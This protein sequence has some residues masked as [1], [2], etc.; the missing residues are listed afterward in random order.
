M[1]H[2]SGM[3]TVNIPIYTINEKGYKLPVS[4]DY[5]S[6]GIKVE[7]VASRVGIGWAL[8]YGGNIS[9][10][11][12]GSADESTY[13]Y[14]NLD[15][16][17]DFFTNS[18]TRSSV[19]SAST[20]HNYDFVPD[21]FY[22]SANG[23][24]GKFIFDQND[25]QPVLQEFE[26]T[27]ISYTIE[28]SKIASF[29]VTDEYGNK[30]Y[31]G[32]S[33]DGSRN[34]RDYDVTKLITQVQGESVVLSNPS[35]TEYY[36]TWHL[37][38]IETPDDGKIEFYYV[39]EIPV[40]YRRSYDKINDDKKP[41]SFFSK[42]IGHQYQ[43]SEIRF[44]TGKLVFQKS[45]TERSDLDNAYAL[46]RVEL[47]D[48]N[49]SLV[50]K[51]QFGYQY[52]TA[53]SNGNQLSY[54][55]T[56]ESQAAKRL[57]LKSIQEK[58]S[59]NNALPAYSFDYNSTVLPNRFSNSQDVWGYYNG[60][61]N[62][63]YLT[64]FNYASYNV[65]R[66]VQG[67]YSGAGLLTKITFPTGGSTEYTY[68]QNVA[69]PSA[70]MRNII[71]QNI[72]PLETVSDGLGFLDLSYYDGRR[73]YIKP[74]TIGNISGVVNVSNFWVQNASI[75]DFN[76]SIEGIGGSPVYSLIPGQTTFIDIGSG[77]Y[78][79]K[80]SP[81]SSGFDP[82][83][84]DHGFNINL[85]WQQ[86]EVNQN[87][88]IYAGGKRINTVVNKLAD[89]SVASRK[90][91]R[92][93]DSQGETTGLIFGMPNCYTLNKELSIG[94]FQVFEAYGAVPGSPLNM[95]Q[96][97]SVG[98]SKVTEYFGT[99][100]SN[101]GRTD[102]EFTDLE[103]TGD[104]YKFPYTM[105]TD[106]E[107]LRGKPL[108]IANYR[109]KT[110]GSFELVK[111]VENEYLYGDYVDEF[112]SSSYNVF[113]PF[114]GMNN[115]I[116]IS[117]SI[118][119][120]L[121]RLYLKNKRL[122]RFPL[123]I[124]AFEMNDYG[125][126]DPNGDVYYKIYHITGGSL[127]LNKTQTTDY[128]N[129][130]ASLITTTDYFYNYDDHYQLSRTETTNSNGDVIK[131]YLRY[132][133]DYNSGVENFNT[134]ISNNI[135]GKVVD[136]RTYNGSLL[137]SGIQNKFNNDGLVTD[138]YK[139]ETDVTDLAFN[140]GNAYT[141]SHEANYHYTNSNLDQVFPE[142]DIKTVYLWDSKG[143]YV[144]A[145]VE[146][147]TYSQLSS[148][149]NKVCTYSSKTLYNNIKSLV[150]GA[151]ITT[152]SYD[153]LIGISE[154]TDTNGVTS[155]FEYDSFGRLKFVKNDDSH[156]QNMVRYNYGSN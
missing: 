115:P 151:I 88:L 136:N 73:A 97:N 70:V 118:T 76:F 5:H 12:R 135:V 1:S 41:E 144:M 104:Y 82:Y 154:Q 39:E 19:Y 109:K 95:G 37:M 68:D 147:A 149:Q 93:V 35:I 77:V 105:P 150:S 139:F 133:Q 89:G 26:N 2:Y 11:V 54:L 10:Q 152:Y 36:N 155:Y 131:N 101:Q 90:E 110:D 103:N 13:G 23:S 99:V 96:G 141:F 98:Y 58:D 48:Q 28:S 15:F 18:T 45:S 67:A 57:F 156:I 130:V 91:Y 29:I 119:P 75:M 81:K 122:F 63:E 114:L 49:N 53:A 60:A 148:L 25:G 22:L 34:A 50:R 21:Q 134:L 51:Y 80:V 78:Y 113:I 145:K 102:Y 17:D 72:N 100:S 106:N 8:N 47:Y 4:V 116:P 143:E 40:Y 3:P 30:Y 108:V 111:K 86:P 24:G 31:Y 6:R 121:D 42:V 56:I 128:V 43:L 126:I 85:S 84:F 64:F 32:K 71:S 107:W 92:Y 140:A 66:T 138:V 120:D 146:N 62:G 124:F 129:G 137:V 125:S 69:M 9:R 52:T 27:L 59:Q 117:T 46:D 132:P 123:A 127:D 33:K 153:P 94:G 142:N 55:K 44:S 112:G 16:Y 20:N 7:E 87:E 38:E 83:N 65:D 79:L 74:I 14:L 61:N